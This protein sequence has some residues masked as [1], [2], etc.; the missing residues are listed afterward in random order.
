MS[1]DALDAI[2][3]ECEV[4]TVGAR[5]V[6]VRP[7]TVGA[8]PAFVRAIR[9]VLPSVNAVLAD[10]DGTTVTE[11][12]I[13]ELL[14]ESEAVIEAV[15]VATRVERAWLDEQTLD[16][17]VVLAAAV[18]KVNSDFFARALV[19]AVTAA[20]GRINGAESG[21]VPSSDLSA[22]DSPAAMSLP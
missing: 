12:Q 20:A 5:E 21:T 16:A 10:V 3:P 6:E 13:V 4:V 11:G 14:G 8:L 2:E 17:L 7:L 15:C 18:F 1:D 9:P 19:P 22:P